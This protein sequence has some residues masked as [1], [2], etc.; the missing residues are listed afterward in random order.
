M[1]KKFV[2]VLNIDNMQVCDMRRFSGIWPEGVNAQIMKIVKKFILS[3][4]LNYYLRPNASI[5]FLAFESTM[6]DVFVF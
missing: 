4:F 1:E 6:E 3:I 5:D 2:S